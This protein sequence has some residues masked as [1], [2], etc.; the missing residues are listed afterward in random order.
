[1]FLIHFFISLSPS[2]IVYFN[3]HKI[4]KIDFHFSLWH[5]IDKFQES[6]GIILESVENIE[7]LI[8]VREMKIYSSFKYPN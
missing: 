3:E 6:F 1:M 5:S 8:D 7:K 2:N 4:M